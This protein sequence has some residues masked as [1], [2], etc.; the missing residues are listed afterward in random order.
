MGTLES[1]LYCAM[2]VALSIV[3]PLLKEALP[4]PA[5][6]AGVGGVWPRVWNKAKG[7]LVIGCYSIA[8]SLIVVASSDAISTWR[9]AL[10]L[11][12]LADSTLQK[13]RS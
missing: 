1:L 4:K 5:G 10:I 7:L 12:Y 13:L 8:V 3:I 2:G 9:N 6:V 11:G